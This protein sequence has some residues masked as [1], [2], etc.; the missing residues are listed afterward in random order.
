MDIADQASDREKWPTGNSPSPRS[1]PP[2][3]RGRRARIA[4]TVASRSRQ[5][6]SR[7]Y[8]A[9]RFAWNANPHKNIKGEPTHDRTN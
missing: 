6:A 2:A 7:P 1:A 3:R 8:P 9:S 5:R 4:W